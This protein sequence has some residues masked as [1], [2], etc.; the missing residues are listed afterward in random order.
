M[1]F[2]RDSSN[3][4]RVYTPWRASR[5]LP[6]GSLMGLAILFAGGCATLQEELPPAVVGERPQPPPPKPPAPPAQPARR[7]SRLIAAAPAIPTR[8]IIAIQALL[9]RQNLSCNCADGVLGQQTRQALRTW[10]GQNGLPATGQLDDATRQKLGPLDNAFTSHVITDD[11]R[12]AL[13][14]VPKTWI[15]KSRVSRL[16]YETIV[17]EVAEKYHASQQTIRDL[18]P[19]VLWPDPPAGT[20][21]VVPNPEP[22]SDPAQAARL[23]ISLGQKLLRAFGADGKLIAQF[24][25]SIAKDKAKRPK[26]EL[27]VIN[28]AKDPNY[29]F[30]PALFIEDPETATIHGKLVIPPGPNNPVGVAWISLSLPGY[31]M[32][33]T[34]KPEDIGK[35]ESHGC[36]RLANWNAAKLMQMISIGVPVEVGD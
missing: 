8:D 2:P 25:C 4:N 24:P 26:G 29:Y 12:A 32:H 23:T 31:G 33:G 5:S 28:C 9:D 34:P 22:T 18:N 3:S 20:R 21:L 36:F 27:R 15:G 11:E 7:P 10:Q 14:A 35:T 13:A 16:G 1:K 30:D 6:I 19:D 17:E